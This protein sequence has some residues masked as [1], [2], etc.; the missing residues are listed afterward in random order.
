MSN[1]LEKYNTTEKNISYSSDVEYR[2]IL[3]KVFFINTSPLND[4]LDDENN[5]K[6]IK[7]MD[8]LLQLTENNEIFEN[9]YSL[10]SSN[11]YYPD[12]RIGQCLLF[13]YDYFDLFHSCLCDFLVEK[14]ITYENTY[15]KMLFDKIKVK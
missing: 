14:K 15:V 6:I 11:M 3:C 10:A 7:T 9:L 13:S 1:I 12:K 8:D 5:T 4:E 2:N